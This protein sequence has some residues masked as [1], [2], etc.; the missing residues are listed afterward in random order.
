MNVI[1]RREGA[2]SAAADALVVGLHA[3]D[4]RWPAS[5]VELDRRAGGQ[6]KAVLEAEKFQAKSG[7]VTH[8]HTPALAAPRLVVAGLGTR[9]DLTL[10]IVRRSAAAAVRRARDLGARTVAI[11]V[12]G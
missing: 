4:R 7:S 11:E 3:E 12:F 9:A 8:I 5:L 1:V 6:I 2:Q 10:E